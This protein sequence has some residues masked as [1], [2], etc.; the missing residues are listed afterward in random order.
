[1]G[2]FNIITGC[3]CGGVMFQ[4]AIARPANQLFAIGCA[5]TQISARSSRPTDKS[6]AS[7]SGNNNKWQRLRVARSSR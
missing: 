3:G 4:L 1:M 5:R 2:N 6:G 7:S